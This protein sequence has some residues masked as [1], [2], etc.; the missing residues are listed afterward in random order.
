MDES[1][2]NWCTYSTTKSPYQHP[3]TWT[4]ASTYTSCHYKSVYTWISITD[5]FHTII[6]K[7]ISVWPQP[8]LLALS[9]QLLT[10]HSWTWNKQKHTMKNASYSMKSTVCLKSAPSPSPN[11]W[12]LRTN[13]KGIFLKQAFWFTPF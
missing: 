1:T 7:K 3:E 5:K 9:G 8:L 6:K 13:I 4:P 2:C 11:V 10:E 12:I